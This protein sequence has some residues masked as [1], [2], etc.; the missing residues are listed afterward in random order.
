MH[1]HTYTVL[2]MNQK[3]IV[4]PFIYPAC[5]TFTESTVYPACST[6]SGSATACIEIAS[7]NHFCNPYCFGQHFQ[8]S[9][10]LRAHI[11]RPP[12][13]LENN[14]TPISYCFRGTLPVTK[15]QQRL[16]TDSQRSRKTVG[17][18][19]AVSA[20]LGLLSYKQN[21]TQDVV[22]S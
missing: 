20:H 1:G 16:L 9:H 5:S 6:F 15:R 2:P 10:F 13:E 19:Q 11:Q 22:A 3:I 4:S 14:F 8:T 21:H 12:Y 7:R 18:L 17:I